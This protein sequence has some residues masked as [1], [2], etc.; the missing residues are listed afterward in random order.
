MPELQQMQSQWFPIYYPMGPRAFQD[1]N[2]D[3]SG[4][5]GA[6]AELTK[7]ISN[8]PILF[9]GLRLTNVYALPTT[10]TELDI[11]VFE[12]SKRY[13]DDEQTVRIALSQQNITAEPT[14]QVQLTGKSG[15]YW[16]PFPVPFPMAGGNNIAVTITRVTSYPDINQLPIHPVIFG[17]I[18][19][20]VA[21]N[22]AQTVPVRRIMQPGV[23]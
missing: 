5:I 9:L 8:W 14:L 15:V 3:A 19:A 10:P 11:R 6:V 2:G 16:A 13:I 22:E 12:A 17:T 23:A 7:E 4:L 1:A 18:I 21:R 20:A